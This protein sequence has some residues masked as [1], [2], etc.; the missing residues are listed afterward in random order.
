MQQPGR[1]VARRLAQIGLVC[2][3]A[4]LTPVAAAAQTPAKPQPPKKPTGPKWEVSFR[5]GFASGSGTPDGLSRTPPAGETFTMADGVTPTRAVS[6]WYFGDGASF[7]NQ[8]LQLRGV[9]A[10][11]DALEL[12]GWPAASRRSGPE[13]GA[14]IARHVKGGVWLEFGVDAGFDPLGFDDEMRE[15][16]ENT[17]ADFEAAFKA[18]AASAPAVIAASTVTSTADFGSSGG[19]VIVSGVVHYR[20]DGPVMRPYLLAGIGAAAPFGDPA[21]LTLTGTNRF[22]PP[23]SS[24]I[25]EIDTIRLGYEA[26]GSVVWIVGGGMMRDLSR[27]SSYR[28]EVRLLSSTTKLSGRLDAEP[29]RLTASPGGALVLNGT[30]PGLQFSSS[31]I[32]PTLSGVAHLRF[33]AFNG[34]GGALQWVLSAAYVRRF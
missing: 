26:S 30:S 22:T 11:I 17:R 2:A 1:L 33:D 24:A 13:I 3:I 29:S 7:L 15:R 18:L 27:K 5:G 32:R 12:R 31:T 19:R 25:E 21:T 8:V 34:E 28:V 23:A 6:S 4:T 16:V 10:R 9:A 14:T 20:G